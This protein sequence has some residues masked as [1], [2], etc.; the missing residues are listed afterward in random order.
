MNRHLK[1]YEYDD[2]NNSIDVVNFFLN[3]YPLPV[4]GILC[5]FFIFTLEQI[6]VYKLMNSTVYFSNLDCEAIRARITRNLEACLVS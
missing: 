4:K 1:Y 5:Y 2:W 3:L 6:V